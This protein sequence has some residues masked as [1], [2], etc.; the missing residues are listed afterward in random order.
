MIAR[1]SSVMI[2]HNQHSVVQFCLS[3]LSAS[4]FMAIYPVF[5]FLSNLFYMKTLKDFRDGHIW[6]SVVSRP[7]NSNFTCVQR[8]SC[9]FSLLLCT[10]LTSIMFYG[11][12][13]D[14]AE[15]TMD[16]GKSLHISLFAK[17]PE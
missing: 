5:N 11:V 12:P 13:T 14:P 9:C 4:E 6:F 2:N 16:L 17:L 1:K 8:V 7:P 10:M 3:F 15:Q